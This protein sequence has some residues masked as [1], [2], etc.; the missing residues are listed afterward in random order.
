MENLKCKVEVGGR[1]PEPQQVEHE[2]E[3]GDIAQRSLGMK[4]ETV[5]VGGGERGHR[6][7]VSA[8]R[9]MASASVGDRGHQAEE[10]SDLA[11]TWMR[12]PRSS[13]RKSLRLQGGAPTSVDKL[14]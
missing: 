14:V 9:R 8:L 2:R 13:S 11:V 1:G 7:G 4:E 3:F 10:L 5:N 12:L 6:G